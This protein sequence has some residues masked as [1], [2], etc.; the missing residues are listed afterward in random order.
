M[1]SA[2][3]T[4]RSGCP[5]TTLW[6]TPAMAVAHRMCGMLKRALRLLAELLAERQ[7]G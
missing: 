3:P 6:R 2:T 7:R 4:M 5:P 1:G